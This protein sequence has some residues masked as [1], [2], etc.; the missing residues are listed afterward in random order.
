MTSALTTL[1]RVLC[2]RDAPMADSDWRFAVPRFPY[3]EHVGTV[4]RFFLR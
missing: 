1:P 3:V 2:M 4:A